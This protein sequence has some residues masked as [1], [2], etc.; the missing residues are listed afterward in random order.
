MIECAFD[1]WSCIG[2]DSGDAKPMSNSPQLTQRPWN[3]LL[4]NPM[5]CEATSH[6]RNKKTM[7][8][9]PSTLPTL[10]LEKPAEGLD[11]K[12]SP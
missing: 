4:S 10:G 8:P 12:P 3:V 11:S 2:L 7:Q 1:I 6:L 5:V 9:K